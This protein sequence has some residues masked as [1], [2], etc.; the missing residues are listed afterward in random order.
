MTFREI[1]KQVML[2]KGLDPS[3]IDTQMKLASSVVQLAAVDREVPPEEVEHL[4]EALSQ[5]HDV[6]QRDPIGTKALLA[7]RIQHIQAKN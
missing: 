3:V 1:A 7:A 4:R 6:A 2:S 5:L